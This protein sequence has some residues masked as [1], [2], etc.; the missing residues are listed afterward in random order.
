M[1]IGPSSSMGLSSSADF[2]NEIIIGTP[3]LILTSERISKANLND[4]ES[5]AQLDNNDNS[6]ENELFCHPSKPSSNLTLFPNFNWVFLHDVWT[7]VMAKFFER[8][9]Y[10]LSVRGRRYT[11]G[12]FRN[13]E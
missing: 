8:H 4:I 5:Q 9:Y 12:K 7:L 1:T 11:N 10:S 13:L 3:S 6:K 2:G